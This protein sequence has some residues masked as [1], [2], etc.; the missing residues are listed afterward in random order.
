MWA[1]SDGRPVG[2]AYLLASLAPAYM[3]KFKKNL[4][5]VGLVSRANLGPG[6]GPYLWAQMSSTAFEPTGFWEPP[7]GFQ[8][9]DRHSERKDQ[10]QVMLTW[11]FLLKMQWALQTMWPK[12]SRPISS[13]TAA[14]AAL[15]PFK[16][17]WQ[18]KR[19]TNAWPLAF[20]GSEGERLH[21]SS[22]GPRFHT[23]SK[24][25]VRDKRAREYVKN[26]TWAHVSVLGSECS[27]L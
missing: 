4:G 11:E 14:S 26:A 27:W 5:L 18:V 13:W 7:A 25:S 9:S 20:A 19:P 8:T 10:S 2:G 22:S 6:L 1:F 16:I 23:K 17:T 3:F 24:M 12:R 15:F 21:S